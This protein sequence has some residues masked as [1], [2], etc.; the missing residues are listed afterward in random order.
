MR[1]LRLEP[2][3]TFEE[4]L[5]QEPARLAGEEERLLADPSYTS[6]AHRHWSYLARGHYADQIE[7]WLT[8]VP[9]DQFLVVRSEAFFADTQATYERVLDFLGL[10]R[11]TP[12]QHRRRNAG[13][14]RAPLAAATR[15]R[16][17]REFATSNE[18]LFDLP[19]QALLVGGRHPPPLPPTPSRSRTPAGPSPHD[20]PLRHP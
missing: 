4:A 17:D 1:R 12:P 5:D 11:W 13:A 8:V 14:D 18:R 20:D 6:H 19:R 15:E 3:A 16:L 10:P 7:H 2:L 9:R